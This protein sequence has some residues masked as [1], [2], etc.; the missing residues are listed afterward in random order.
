[1]VSGDPR[2]ADEYSPYCYRILVDGTDRSAY[3]YVNRGL[4][5]F[6]DPR[7]KQ[8]PTVQ[9]A[10]L[11]DVQTRRRE[12][13]PVIQRANVTRRPW[14]GVMFPHIPVGKVLSLRANGT[15]VTFQRADSDAS[16]PPPDFR[17]D[18]RLLG[19]EVLQHCPFEMYIGLGSLGSRIHLEG[20][21]VILK[22]MLLYTQCSATI[23]KPGADEG[24][25]FPI[26][27]LSGSQLME[28]YPNLK[29]LV[30]QW[31]VMGTYLVFPAISAGDELK[32]LIF[33]PGGGKQIPI[34][35]RKD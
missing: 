33:L 24:Q 2:L 17:L 11:V 26:Q 34:Y 25:P 23:H 30:H 9:D 1:M 16:R 29:K 28:R 19:Y 20:Q 15:L 5:T 12:N 6:A 18:N 3:Q 31:G 27:R 22:I 21:N 13:P 7:W 32:I 8:D 35:V 14:G 10:R 4:V